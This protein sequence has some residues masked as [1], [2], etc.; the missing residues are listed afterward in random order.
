MQK[1]IYI[2]FG[3]MFNFF[4]LLTHS[5]KFAHLV[6]V[7]LLCLLIGIPASASVNNI[8]SSQTLTTIDSISNYQPPIKPDY[9]KQSNMST[10]LYLV[11][12]PESQDTWLVSSTDYKQFMVDKK[13]II[14]SKESRFSDS[15]IGDLVH[16]S[17]TFKSDIKTKI[18]PFFVEI[19]RDESDNHIIWGWVPLA[20]V[21]NLSKME[22]IN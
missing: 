22:G 10:D 15:S 18:E 7:I 17:V 2:K 9:A 4:Y 1:F 19:T 5:M 6:L 12:H 16:V 11:L 14:S 20:K 21:E 3:K 13:V 8:V